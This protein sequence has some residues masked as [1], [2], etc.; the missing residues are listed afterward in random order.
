MT[1]QAFKFKLTVPN[2]PNLAAM[3]AEVARHA[4]EYAN[5]DDA[6]AA[7]FAERARDA[8]ATALQSASGHHCLLVFTAADGTLSVT[9]GTETISQPLSLS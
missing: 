1:P 8:A 2:D 5:L 7:G 9:I 4:A 6:A 3:V